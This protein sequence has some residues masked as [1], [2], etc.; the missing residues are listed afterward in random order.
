MAAEEYEMRLTARRSSL[1]S[2]DQSSARLGNIRL[3]VVIAALACIYWT[4]WWGLAATVLIFFGIGIR[5]QSLTTA[6]QRLE[7]A[8]SFYE[9]SIARLNGKWIGTGN[10]GDQHLPE[11]HLYARDLDLFGRGSLFELLCQA[12]TRTGEQT[13]AHWLLNPA[14]SESITQRQQAVQELTPNL[15]LREDLAVLGAGKQR[16]LRAAALS[17]WG[18][19]PATFH[20]VPRTLFRI[21]SLFGAAAA[22][23]LIADILGAELPWLR[24]GY[25]S[26]AL[27]CGGILWRYRKKSGTF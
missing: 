24:I 26:M 12:R 13:L 23:A 9:Q 16:Q 19:A 17:A 5:I 21:V 10:S 1:A 4:N 14:P 8:A 22:C 20:K 6:Q 25:L 2:S 7:R 27:V 3:I 18:E 11:E 15:N